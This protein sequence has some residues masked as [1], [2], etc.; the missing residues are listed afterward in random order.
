[1][2]DFT[3]TEKAMRPAATLRACF[4]CAEP[5]GG[6]HKASC[7]LVSKRV[8]VRATIEYEI[9][10]PA[11]FGQAAIEFQRNDGTWC[12]DNMIRELEALKEAD[13]CLC[14]RTIFTYLGDASEPF[15]SEG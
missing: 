3:V 14:P 5:V 4:Y 1:M 13:G 6:Q 7:V 12:A 11:S 15:L 2:S 8:K 10:V 9:E